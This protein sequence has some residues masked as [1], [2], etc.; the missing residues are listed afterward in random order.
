VN[1]E[2]RTNWQAIAADRAHEVEVLTE[3]L[4]QMLE[5]G[6]HLQT[7]LL[8]AEQ[9]AEAAKVEVQRLLGEVE[10][11]E[12]EVERRWLLDEP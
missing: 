7:R 8:E 12:R 9:R 2:P 3:A 10:R 5:A 6:K 1:E 11:L 4:A